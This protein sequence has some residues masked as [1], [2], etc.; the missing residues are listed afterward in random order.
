MATASNSEA[1]SLLEL[2]SEA[3]N[4]RV[5]LECREDYTQCIS[6]V[7]TEYS[8]ALKHLPRIEIIAVGVVSETF[9]S[10]DCH[11]VYQK[12]ALYKGDVFTK[13]L[14]PA[15]FEPAIERLGLGRLTVSVCE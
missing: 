15:M 12:S 4:R 8:A 9:A 10:D 5:T 11:I 6:T 2:F 14:S 13:R 1:L 7:R 3:M